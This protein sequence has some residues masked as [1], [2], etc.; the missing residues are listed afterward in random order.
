L[1]VGIKK[2]ILAVETA[3]QDEDKAGRFASVMSRAVVEVRSLGVDVERDSGGGY[4]T[5]VRG[6]TAQ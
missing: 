2:I 4:S 3:L 5:E 1:G 6:Y